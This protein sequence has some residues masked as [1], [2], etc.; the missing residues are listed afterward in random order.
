M[1][2]VLRLCSSLSH[3]N[4]S[5]NDETG[6]GFGAVMRWVLAGREAAG[7]CVLRGMLACLALCSLVASLVL[8]VLA[9]CY[10]E[11]GSDAP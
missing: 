1:S 9:S 10:A 5:L 8:F 7:S 3:L 4:L 11:S 2:G 6:D